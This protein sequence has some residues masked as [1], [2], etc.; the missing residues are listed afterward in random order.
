MILLFLF[1]ILSHTLYEDT[2]FIHSRISLIRVCVPNSFVFEILNGHRSMETKRISRAFWWIRQNVVNRH[3]L[4]HMPND[5]MPL[6]AP[7][8]PIRFIWFHFVLFLRSIWNL[9][10][11]LVFY[12][13]AISL[14]LSTWSQKL[15]FSFC[16]I[17]RIFNSI[18]VLLL[19]LLLCA[20]LVLFLFSFLELFVHLK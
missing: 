14:T 12:F 1:L 7:L 9:I 19:H 11:G 17:I 8:V 5:L 2:S 3:S 16:Q 15:Y 13:H 6:S 20:L 18:C 10:S 4:T